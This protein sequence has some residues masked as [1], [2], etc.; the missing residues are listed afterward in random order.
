MFELNN[1]PQT[2]RQLQVLGTPDPAAFEVATR[3]YQA[4][5]ELPI[6][7]G[8]KRSLDIWFLQNST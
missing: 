4:R 6:A 3:L 1:V 7:H 5:Q 2:K 8:Y